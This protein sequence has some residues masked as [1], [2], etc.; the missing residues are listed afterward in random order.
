MT[1]Q[2]ITRSRETTVLNPRFTN[3][4]PAAPLKISPPRPTSLPTP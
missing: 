4:L 1:W 2:W 3:F